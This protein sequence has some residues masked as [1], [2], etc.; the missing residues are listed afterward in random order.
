VTVA[1]SAPALVRVRGTLATLEITP[2]DRGAVSLV[3]DGTNINATAGVPLKSE[4]LAQPNHRRQRAERDTITPQQYGA[5]VTASATIQPRAE[6]VECS[7]SGKSF[8]AP[9][10]STWRVP[11]DSYRIN[12]LTIEAGVLQ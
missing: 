5:S 6:R 1:T 7:Q 9:Q 3:D 8:I 12:G 2:A 10:A 4:P 11:F